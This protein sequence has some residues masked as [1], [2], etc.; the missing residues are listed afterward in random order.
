MDFIFPFIP[1]LFHCMC[2][3]F[4]L[5]YVVGK[6]DEGNN[7]ECFKKGELP[8]NI[9]DYFDPVLK[10]GGPEKYFTKYLYQSSFGQFIVLGD[11]LDKVVYLD[12]CPPSNP[13]NNSWSEK[14]NAAIKTQ[15]GDTL[16]LH[17][18]TPLNEFDNYNLANPN[19]AGIPKSPQKNG[20]FDC[21][22]YL[23]K[24]YPVFSGYSGYGLN[25]IG[26]SNPLVGNMGVD[27]GGVF[28]HTG[29]V[30]SIKFIMEEFFH[31]MYGGNNWHDGAGKS[32]HTFLAHT[33]PWGIPSQHG[34][35]QVVSGYDRW[36]FHWNSP[37]EKY[38]FISARDANNN[39]INTDLTLPSDTVEQFFVLRDFVTTG[40]AVR[41][42]LP[43]I[44]YGKTGPEK[45]QYLWLENHQLLSNSIEDQNANFTLAKTPFC[46]PYPVCG[47]FW[48]P[49]IFSIMEVGKDITT[50]P[51]IYSPGSGHPNALASWLFPLDAEG[52]FDFKYSDVIHPQWAPC[53]GTVPYVLFDLRSS[54]LPNPFSGFSTIFGQPN[55]DSSD[56]L[57]DHDVIQGVGYIN[58]NGDT[59]L[60]R[61]A[62]GG[63]N[64][65]FNCIG[66]CPPQGKKILSL[67]TNPSPVPVMTYTS[68]DNFLSS[69]KMDIN[70]YSP[71]ENR[72]IYLNGLSVT[73]LENN[74]DVERFGE[75]AIKIKIKWNDYVVD[76]KVRWCAD[77]IRLNANDFDSSKYS[78]IIKKDASVWIDRGKSPT[79]DYSDKI[80]NGFT[81]PT[82]FS[83]L[84][85]SNISI[86]SGG[87]LII[88]NGSLLELETN[89][90]IDISEG[91]KIIVRNGGMLHLKNGAKIN[92][93]RRAR[94]IIE[95]DG[96]QKKDDGA[97]IKK[98]WKK[99]SE[100]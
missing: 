68:G 85:N 26:S 11:Y 24:N 22:V 100:L 70:K 28:G 17:Y 77:S 41:I 96:M 59:I 13:T 45:N 44:E 98:R 78:L 40:D 92:V 16:P 10:P 36:I 5:N 34:M 30:G 43:H 64:T 29:N 37:P 86:E 35:S 81:A 19:I 38:L 66:K 3:L 6:C 39:E 50:G 61:S 55:T 93:S 49:G 84:E 14:I 90:K 63:S 27:I 79:Y 1:V 33:R 32:N 7:P 42:K 21:V 83:C 87:E 62:F 23:V 91:A 8:V 18:S 80:R 71:Y 15:F 99:M 2:L 52:N 54:P 94:I 76:N 60:N 65:S 46:D 67:S 95:K 53:T 51:N 88:D 31:A 69:R 72:T 4:L 89:S 56:A 12:F 25:M 73:I 48:S 74:F 58:S 75:G 97:V 20:K 57:F 82:V 47:E 9:D